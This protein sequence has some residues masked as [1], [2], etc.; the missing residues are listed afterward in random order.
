MHPIRQLALAGVGSL[1]AL[2]LLATAAHAD[3]S[4]TYNVKFEDVS[5]NCTTQKLAYKPQPISI[6]VK[7]NQLT[8]DID[9]TPVMVG[10]PT[11]SGKISAKSRAGN[12]MMDG[13]KGVF[14]VAG[15]VLVDGSLSLVMVGEY[16]TDAGKSLCTQSWNVTGSKTAAKPRK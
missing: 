11:K 2:G 7:G 16:S 3:V 12:T 1:V 10:V 9:L 15:K 13:M 14:S 8:V 6:K 5:T 4:G